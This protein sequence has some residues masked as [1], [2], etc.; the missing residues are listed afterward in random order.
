[1]F[2]TVI[3]KSIMSRGRTLAMALAGNSI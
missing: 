3:G 1:V 2:V